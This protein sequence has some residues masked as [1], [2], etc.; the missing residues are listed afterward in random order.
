MA[1]NARRTRT[2]AWR[3]NKAML[4]RKDWDLQQ[5]EFQRGTLRGF[6]V[7]YFSTCQFSEATGFTGRAPAE[8]GAG[9]CGGQKV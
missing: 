8:R 1:D 2:L 3:P 7:D 5:D 9:V 6:P 4:R